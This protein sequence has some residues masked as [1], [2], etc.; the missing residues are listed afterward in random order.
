MQNFL[1]VLINGLVICTNTYDKLCKT[2]VCDF[3]YSRRLNINNYVQFLTNSD[4]KKL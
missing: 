4:L 2:L 3:I 1:E